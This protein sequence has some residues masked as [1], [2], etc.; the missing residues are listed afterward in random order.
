MMNRETGS[1]SSRGVRP[2]FPADMKNTPFFKL[3]P[4]FFF[5]IIGLWLRPDHNLK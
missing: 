5:D 1:Y 2:S 4:F 3:K